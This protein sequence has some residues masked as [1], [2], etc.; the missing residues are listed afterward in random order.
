MPLP[1]GGVTPQVLAQI[2]AR[3]QIGQPPI[4]PNPGMLPMMLPLVQAPS[5]LLSWQG[6]YPPPEAVERYEKILPGTFDRML[7]MAE[8]L[9]EAQINQSRDAVNYTMEDTRRAHWLGWGLGIFAL[10]VAIGCAWLGYPWLG[11]AALSVPVMGLGTALVNSAR[12]NSAAKD[13]AAIAGPSAETKPPADNP[14][15]HEA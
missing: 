7:S 12:G 13:I 3:M 10:V 2:M 8:R 5:T 15:S 6:P 9:Q 4:G 14:P 11:A 1:Q